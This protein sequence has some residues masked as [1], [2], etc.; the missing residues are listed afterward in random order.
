MKK[1][2]LASIA[3]TFSDDDKYIWNCKETWWWLWDH[4]NAS[5]HRNQSCQSVWFVQFLVI[6]QRSR[7]SWWCHWFLLDVSAQKRTTL[8]VEIIKGMS[9]LRPIWI[10]MQLW[11][12]YVCVLIAIYDAPPIDRICEIILITKVENITFK[13]RSKFLGHA[14]EILLDNVCVKRRNERNVDKFL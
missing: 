7:W 3:M 12:R 8:C 2:W 9:F 4:P 11:L 5:V 1:Q 13:S 10:H 14:E 6:F